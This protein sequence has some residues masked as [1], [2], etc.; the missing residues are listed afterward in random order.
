MNGR[1]AVRGILL[2]L[3]V[4]WGARPI[5]GR[6]FANV[7]VGE[8]VEDAELRTIDG[9]RASLFAKGAKADVVVFFR[10]QQEHSTD[11][12]RE[13]AA[14][15]RELAGKPVHW[16]GVVSSSWA[17]AE[18]RAVVTETGIRMPV[19]VD[20]GDALY[21]RFGVRLHPTVGVLDESRRLAAYEPFRQINYCERVKARIRLVLGEL[22]EAAV[23]KLDSPE[24]SITRTDEGVARRH[25][26]YARMLLRIQ[27]L[28]RALAEVEKVLAVAPTAAGY[29]LQG[30]ILA[31]QGKCAEAIRAFDAALKID[32]ASSVAVDGRKSCGR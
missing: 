31:A 23:A 8:V 28:D 7:A 21:G 12:L 6:A 5:A 9:G 3:V 11:A 10:P 27:K 15:Q 25:L 26:N 32:P 18:V 20:E 13:L 19:L 14:C 1:F 4:V 30:E 16:V 24:R 17:P 22:D 2:G 29:A